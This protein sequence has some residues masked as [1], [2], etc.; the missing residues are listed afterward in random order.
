MIILW[1]PISSA[2]PNGGG[3][4]FELVRNHYRELVL[5][6]SWKKYVNRDSTTNAANYNLAGVSIVCAIMIGIGVWVCCRVF[7]KKV[8]TT[9]LIPQFHQAA[10]GTSGTESW[11]AGI[12]RLGG[13]WSG[14]CS[15][16]V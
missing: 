6:T 2:T 12:Y 5:I 8:T 1:G 13:V 7:E 10:M 9:V 16:T 15:T 4:F 11:A 14:G 3:S